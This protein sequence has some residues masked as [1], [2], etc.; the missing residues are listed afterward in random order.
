[1]MQLRVMM[2]MTGEGEHHQDEYGGGCG[3]RGCGN[4]RRSVARRG[5]STRMYGP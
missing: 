1:M 3:G 5:L 4:L 2:T